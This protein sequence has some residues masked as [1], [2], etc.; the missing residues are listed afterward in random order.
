MLHNL[1]SEKKKK[2]VVIGN[3]EEK[4]VVRPKYCNFYASE[5]LRKKKIEL[6]LRNHR[7]HKLCTKSKQAETVHNEQEI[8]QLSER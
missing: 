3:R 4:A 2:R 5:L 6:R 8:K 7:P 1:S